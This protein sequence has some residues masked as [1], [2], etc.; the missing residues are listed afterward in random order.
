MAQATTSVQADLD[1][2]LD[3]IAS[4]K[5]IL[6]DAYAPEAT[7]EDLAKAI[8]DALDELSDYES[9]EEEGDDEDDDA[10]ED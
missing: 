5:G 10:G 1:E 9:D 3:S 6:E 2:A 7:R 8:G 4:V